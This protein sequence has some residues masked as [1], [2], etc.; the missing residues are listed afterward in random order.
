MLANDTDVDGDTLALSRFTEP[1]HGEVTQ[2]GTSLV[3]KPV[4]DYHGSDAFTYTAGD[5]QGGT[6]TA[7]VHLDNSGGYGGYGGYG[8]SRGKILEVD[9][10]R[11]SVFSGNYTAY[12]KQREERRLAWRWETQPEMPP[13]LEA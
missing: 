3:Y 12:T 10:G 8:G 11:V 1:A 5:G 13:G 2:S 6:A 7:T 4:A 9:S